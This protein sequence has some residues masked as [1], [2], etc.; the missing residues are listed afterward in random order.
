[1]QLQQWHRI[2]ALAAILFSFAVADVWAAAAPPGA[3]VFKTPQ[4]AIDALLAAA[5]ES[6][7][8]DLLA[9]LGPEGKDV[10]SSGDETA[11]KAGRD[12]LLAAAKEK[13]VV[14]TMSKTGVTVT[15]GPDA[16]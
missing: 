1:K 5:A 9:V 16:W 7:T 10:V 4:A 15:R 3:K 14:L 2:G 6:E 13:T 8:G 12:A 11:D